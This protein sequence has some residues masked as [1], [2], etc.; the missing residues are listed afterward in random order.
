MNYVKTAFIRFDVCSV[1]GRRL[2]N[3]WSEWHDYSIF[4]ALMMNGISF[5]F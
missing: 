4:I 1:Y 3:W 2:F 5:L